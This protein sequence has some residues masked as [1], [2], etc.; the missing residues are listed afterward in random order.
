MNGKLE[1]L[2]QV[3]A[4]LV[5]AQQ[6]REVADEAARAASERDSVKRWIHAGS[7]ARAVGV[8]YDFEG[9]FSKWYLSGKERFAGAPA[10][11][12]Y[13]CDNPNTNRGLRFDE[14]NDGLAIIKWHQ[15]RGEA[16]TALVVWDAL[17]QSRALLLRESPE[18]ASV[19]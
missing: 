8:A 4:E 17:A 10:C 14:K 15:A 6:A 2:R 3:D 13:F 12:S 5:A 18:L 7:I 1:R 11:V 16:R 19:A 9:V